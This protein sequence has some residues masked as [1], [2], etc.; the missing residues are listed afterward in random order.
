MNYVEV[1]LA[2]HNRSTSQ[3]IFIPNLHTKCCKPTKIIT[4]QKW[5]DPTIFKLPL[6]TTPKGC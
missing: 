1:K 4:V 5:S 3:H 6:T 2:L